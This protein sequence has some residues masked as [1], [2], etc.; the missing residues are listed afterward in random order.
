MPGTLSTPLGWDRERL[1]QSGVSQSKLD[2]WVEKAPWVEALAL[3]GICSLFCIAVPRFKHVP[4]T[5][6]VNIILSAIMLN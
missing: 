6:T 5:S 3:A 1:S 4:Q 2:P